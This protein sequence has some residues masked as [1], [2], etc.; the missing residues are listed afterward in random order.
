M[1][2]LIINAF[3]SSLKA[4]QRFESFCNIIKNIF[5]K[6]SKGSGIEN[7]NF[8]CRNPKNILEYIYKHDMI[9]GDVNQNKKNKKN[10]DKIDIVIIDGYE[11]YAPWDPRS[12]ALCEFIKLCKI[13]NKALYAGGVGFEILLYYLSTGTLNEYNFINSK[14]QVKSLEEM[15]N[16]PKSFL[17]EIKPNEI[18]LDYVTGDI[19]E[20]KRN[21]I[22]SPIKNI[23]MHKQIIAE[24]YFQRGKF[25]LRE[26]FKGKDSIKNMNAFSTAVDELKIKITKHYFHH[27]LFENFP[28]EFI[29]STTMTWFP[30]FV[31]V[32]NQNLQ[33]KIL[34][35]CD[36]GPV[37]IEHNNSVGA[38]FHI[39]DKYKDSIHFMEN[40]I[41]KKFKEIQNKIFKFKYTESEYLPKKEK[42][43]IPAIFKYY[44]SSNNYKKNNKN[45]EDI[46]TTNLDRVANSLAFSHIKNIKDE[47]NHVG[48][49]LNN[50][51]MI[52]VENNFINQSSIVST[53]KGR[54][55][56]FLNLK[57][58]IDE[59]IYH[60]RYS[61]IF[62]FKMMLR[63]NFAK[64]DMERN[65]LKTPHNYKNNISNEKSND[66]IKLKKRNIFLSYN[67]KKSKVN[68]KNNN[69]FLLPK[70]VFKNK[71]KLKPPKI[72]NRTINGSSTRRKLGL[73]FESNHEKPQFPIALKKSININNE[74]NNNNEEEF[75]EF[76]APKYPRPAI[77]SDKKTERKN[78]SYLF[79]FENN[80]K[81]DK[82]SNSTNANFFEL[83]KL[84][85]KKFRTIFP[86]NSLI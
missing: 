52:F 34:S 67:K 25:V 36:K 28:I 30:H 27:Y 68:N 19:L 73:N 32:L 3:G 59:P 1:N 48:F 20:Y 43:E 66:N 8:I 39:M 62:S 26:C 50:R 38:I 7:C 60:K 53:K 17:N 2:V 49:G 15:S 72:T 46:K 75:D 83:G 81:N 86:K 74:N 55:I 5:K 9:S 47:A 64:L 11:K 22:W 58:E 51:D 41:K 45:F 77:L 6:I 33:Y 13:T 44:I 10:F 79:N 71:L 65:S 31:N 78:F 4:L 16:A 42:N 21:E 24:K 35:E 57:E 23:G 69:F 80:E 18:F 82:E 40:F 54:N 84:D 85:K 61:D 29:A 70:N 12:Y 63:K 14:G 76:Y 37:I 56:S